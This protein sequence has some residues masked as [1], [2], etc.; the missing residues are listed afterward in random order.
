MF[1]LVSKLLKGFL[2]PLTWIL[3]LLLLALM[4]KDKK[5]QK[6]R[7]IVV[8]VAVGLFLIFSDR[9]LLQYVQYLST[10]EHIA[11]KDPDR[12]YPVAIIMGGFGC[13]NVENN[14]LN[15]T[16][17]R[18][19]RL[20]E[21]VRLHHKGII[22]RIFVTGDATVDSDDE[23]NSNFDAFRTYL[24]QFGIPDSNILAE[25]KA[26]NTRENATFS[27]AKL[28]SLGFTPNDCLLVTSST[29]MKRSLG[30][31]AAEGWE[32]DGYA[33]NIYP[34]PGKFKLT[35]FWPS[36]HAL[37]GWEEMINEWGGNVAYKMAGY[38]K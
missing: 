36:Y 32:L 27:I 37:V 22:G 5:F 2:F 19:P 25:Q 12:Y 24:S 8:I 1:Y 38:K 6:S 9:P 34:K 7:Q 23:G 18:G 35:D 16:F 29:H 28:D 4:L 13:M 30:A 21:P 3:G 26:R 17:D 33:V 14:Q 20:F 15:T 10:K 31:F 11:Q